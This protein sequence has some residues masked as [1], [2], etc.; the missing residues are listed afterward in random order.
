MELYCIAPRRG[1][2]ISLADAVPQEDA[3]NVPRLGDAGA[4]VLGTTTIPE[5][6][7]EGMTDTLLHG[8]T[9]TSFDPDQI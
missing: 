4:I 7:H 5:F 9:V 8:T 1:V 2:E 6:G 3:T